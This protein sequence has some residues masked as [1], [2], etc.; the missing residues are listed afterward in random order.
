[1]NP[2]QHGICPNP[3]KCLVYAGK[4]AVAATSQDHACAI[5]LFQIS[6]IPSGLISSEA[7]NVNL[8]YM[9]PDKKQQLI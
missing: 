2:G 3:L 5:D 4:P 7:L 1:M 6:L 9:N 8:H